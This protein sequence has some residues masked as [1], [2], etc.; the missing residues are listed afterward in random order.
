VVFARALVQEPDLLLLDEPTA[1]LDLRHRVDVLGRVRALAD[2]GHAA[3]VVT[4]DIGLAARVCDRIALLAD[5]RLVAQG[6]P[7]DVIEPDA[8]ERT[9]G[10]RAEV[11]EAPDGSPLVIPAISASPR[12]RRERDAGAC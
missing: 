6:S 3:L 7:S 10:I 5:G 11:I 4:H 9:F 8:L 2:A 1:F 12:L